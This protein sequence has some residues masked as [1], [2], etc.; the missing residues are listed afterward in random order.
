MTQL[1]EQIHITDE[2]LKSLK[3]RGVHEEDI[4]RVLKEIY[5]I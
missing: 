4:V 2:E 1:L 5:E 3:I